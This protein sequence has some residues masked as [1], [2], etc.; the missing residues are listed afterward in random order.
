MRPVYVNLY[1]FDPITDEEFQVSE[2]ALVEIAKI[3]DYNPLVGFNPLRLR[4]DTQN[5]LFSAKAPR[6]NIS[7]SHY[8]RVIFKKVNFSKKRKNLLAHGSISADAQP[9]YVPAR[10]PYWDSGWD[11][12][13]ET[14]EFFDDRGV[15][16]DSSQD[17]PLALKIPIRQVFN[18]GHRG[19]PHHFPENTIASFQKA[20]DL[21]A[22]GL[23]FDLCL[24][25]DKK[26]VLFHD[27][28]PIRHPGQLN[29]TIFENLPYELVSPDFTWNGRYA[30]IKELKNGKY[31]TKKKIQL[32]SGDQFDIV[33]LTLSQVRK[34]YKYHHVEGVEYDIPDLDEFLTFVSTERRRIS[35]LYFDTKNPDWDEDEDRLRFMEFGKIIARTVK[36]YENLSPRMILSNP[37]IKVLQYLKE[38]LL[39]EGETRFEYTFDSQG[40]IGAL[41]GFKENPLKTA[42]KLD[43]TV[44]SIGSLLRPGNLDEIIE[45][46]RDRDYNDKSHLNTVLH[47]TLND[48][49]QMY[50]S[51]IAGING[52]ITD[53]PDELKHVLK[54]LKVRA[55]KL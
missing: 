33:N 15:K 23:E 41:F 55:S 48:P 6:Y 2:G 9:V 54:R 12:G 32:K 19:A 29:R 4:Y 8:F 27:P 26:I 11:D 45:A 51:F 50:Q 44:I 14:N 17:A 1:L 3:F 49:S 30:I 34:Y 16:F 5:K 24:T 53:K 20:L 31:R 10:L 18:I 40:S 37:S 7:K 52:I 36:K 21:G 39:D 46:V 28:Q 43:N 22:N 47:W 42:R 25:K 38:S 13:Y 35:M